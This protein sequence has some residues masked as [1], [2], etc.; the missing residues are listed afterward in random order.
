MESLSHKPSLY[1]LM[2]RFEFS[3]TLNTHLHPIVFL[4]DGKFAIIQVPVFIKK[5]YSA[6]AMNTLGS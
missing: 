4:Y 6:F 2:L 5:L 1:L 3:L